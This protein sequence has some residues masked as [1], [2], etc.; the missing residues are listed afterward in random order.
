M[1][2]NQLDGQGG[3]GPFPIRVLGPHERAR[4]DAESWG[5]LLGLA[6]AGVLDPAELE[7]VID[8]AML[9]IDGTI[10]LPELR[11]ILGDGIND[12]PPVDASSITVH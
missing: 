4:F 1:T 8:R 7:I 10:T 11:S 12:G 2:Q 6:R 5:H 3:H 9:H